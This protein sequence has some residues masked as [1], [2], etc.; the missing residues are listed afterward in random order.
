MDAAAPP[1]TVD[2]SVIVVNYNTRHLLDEMMA[3]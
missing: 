3:A 1:G 2:V